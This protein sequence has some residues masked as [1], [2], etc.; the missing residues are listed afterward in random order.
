MTDIYEKIISSIENGKSG[1]LITVTEKDGFGPGKI[2]SKMFVASS[3]QRT[4]SIGGGPLE[5]LVLKDCKEVLENKQCAAKTYTLDSEKERL[6]SQTVDMLCGGTVKLFFEYIGPK[7]EIFL[8]GIGNV[9]REILVSLS[10]LDYSVCVFEERSDVQVPEVKLSCKIIKDY[11]AAIKEYKFP[12]RGIYIIC[13]YS[14]EKDYEVLRELLM[15]KTDAFYIGMLASEKKAGMIVSK[16]KKENPDVDLSVLY[17]PIG[18]DIGGQTPS[19]IAVSVT[20]QIQAAMYGK[21]APGLSRK[22][23]S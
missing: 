20:A 22:W 9:G 23:S 16:I 4:G 17:S 15:K 6:D 14:H 5:M 11:I 2:G 18:L 7:A 19:E 3:M 21:Q 12:K 1:V 8:F 13:T 10:R